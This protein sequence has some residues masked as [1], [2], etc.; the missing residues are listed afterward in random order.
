MP[1]GLFQRI[2]WML[3]IQEFLPLGHTELLLRPALLPTRFHINNCGNQHVHTRP[4]ASR[5]TGLSDSGQV[6]HLY[7]Y[8]RLILHFLLGF[9]SYHA[10]EQGKKTAAEWLIQVWPASELF[11]A[12]YAA[13]TTTFY[14]RRFRAV[15]LLSE[16]CFR[17]VSWYVIQFA[18]GDCRCSFTPAQSSLCISG[19]LRKR[20]WVL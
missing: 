5:T 4:I 16:H 11:D 15:T 6:F 17:Q 14:C 13:W 10:I 2:R 3:D 1:Y 12:A 9:T 7:D 20:L 18:D 19:I 8:T